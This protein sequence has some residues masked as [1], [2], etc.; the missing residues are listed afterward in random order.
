M[1]LGMERT[2]GGVEDGP[3]R[4]AP[5]PNAC[6][7]LQDTLHKQPRGDGFIHTHFLGPQGLVMSR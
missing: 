4:E 5:V 2:G 1:G 7:S 6:H 3:P